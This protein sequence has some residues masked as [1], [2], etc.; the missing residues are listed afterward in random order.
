MRYT[1][2]LTDWSD[3]KGYG[4]VLQNGS[5]SRVFVHVKSFES[6]PK[7][8]SAG[9]LISYRLQKDHLGR[10]NAVDI[11]FAGL[12]G[13][14]ARM[15]KMMTGGT[16]FATAFIIVIAAGW[17]LGKIPLIILLGYGILGVVT[18]LFY[19]LDKYRAVKNLWRTSEMTL[20]LLAFLGGWPGALFAQNV[21]HHKSRKKKFQ[22]I[23][24][25]TVLLNCLLFVWLLYSGVAYRFDSD[26]LRRA[27]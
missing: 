7:W 12:A 25:C 11:R 16:V 13:I 23:F 1:G 20:H 2:K 22:L 8:P 21:F 14:G 27:G 17:M 3:T 5:G 15:Q 9:D 19:G 18:F 10:P 6:L 26:L 24:W 4:F